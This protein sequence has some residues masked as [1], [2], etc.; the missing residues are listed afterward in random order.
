M[1]FSHLAS[2]EGNNAIHVLCHLFLENFNYNLKLQKLNLGFETLFT[3]KNKN[4]LQKG[5]KK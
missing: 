3:E 1:C 2:Y 5:E 4:R